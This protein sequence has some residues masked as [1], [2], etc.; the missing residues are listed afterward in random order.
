MISGL[1]CYRT[2]ILIN[3]CVQLTLSRLLSSTSAPYQRAGRIPRPH[4]LCMCLH[5]PT[6]HR[7][8]RQFVFFTMWNFSTICLGA[9]LYDNNSTC[10]KAGIFRKRRNSLTHGCTQPWLKGRDHLLQYQAAA[11]YLHWILKSLKVEP[12]LLWL[13]EGHS[14]VIVTLL[15]WQENSKAIT[16]YLALRDIIR[17]IN[18][19]YFGTISLE[20]NN[21]KSVRTQRLLLIILIKEM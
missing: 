15:N 3:Y 12:E 17:F 4:S 16:L 11:R 14:F 20:L 18:K 9:V 7:A 10:P 19:I 5:R 6:A 8:G 21:L 1:P 13:S 2:F